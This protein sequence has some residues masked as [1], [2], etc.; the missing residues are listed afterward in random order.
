MR[1]S[2]IRFILTSLAGI[3]L[4]CGAAFAQS[5]NLPKKLSGIVTSG[6]S[7]NGQRI[8]VNLDPA[9]GSGTLSL[10]F[11]EDRCTIRNAPMNMTMLGGRIT[12]KSVAGY[13]TLCVTTMSLELVPNP[14]RDGEIGYRAELTIT[15]S[16]AGKGPILRGRV[17]QP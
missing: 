10:A 13:A 12:L 11:R 3:A 1:S 9:A 17:T 2:P 8:F 6:D 16:A 7:R 5:S 15:G 4:T 14:G